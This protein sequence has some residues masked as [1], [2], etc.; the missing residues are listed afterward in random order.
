MI[1]DKETNFVYISDLLEKQAS[2][3]FE[4]LK[5]WFDKLEIKYATLPN[6]K[7]LWV[8]DFMPLQINQNYFL[9]YKYDPDYLK[10]KKYQPTRT[11]QKIICEEIG[12]VPNKVAIVLDGGNVVKCKTK[13]ILTTKVFKEN[14]GYPEHN[15]IAE[16]KNQLQVEQVIII[17]QEPKDFVGHSDG[18]VRFINEDTVLVNQYPKDK[19]YEDFAYSLRWSLRNAG[20]NY[21][22][23]P[24]TA[25]QNKDGNDATGCY[26]NFLEIGNYIFY[27]VFADYSDQLALIQ[28]QNVFKDRKFIDIDCR[29]LAKLGGVLNCATWNILK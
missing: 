29:D 2:T 22:E 9:Q 26:I 23:F 4:Q 18:M 25:W 11:D 15:L 21:V 7:D 16:I 20:L 1:T 12:L 14:N 13:A 5:H 24:Y 8:V 3:A 10:P 6:T 17:P 19:T 28:L 27:P